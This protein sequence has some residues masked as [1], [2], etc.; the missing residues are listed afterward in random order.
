MS[1]FGLKVNPGV[2]GV[3]PA[4]GIDSAL[5]AA[6]LDV[7]QTSAPA[8]EDGLILV[9]LFSPLPL[10]FS[11]FELHH[12]VSHGPVTLFNYTDLILH[13]VPISMQLVPR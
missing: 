7:G 12:Q 6:I 5:A 1:I 3:C 13:D 9:E 2:G 8:A 11:G 10:E 4:A